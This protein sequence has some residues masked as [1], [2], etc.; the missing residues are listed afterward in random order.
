MKVSWYLWQPPVARQEEEEQEE[1]E[2]GE[3]ED[4]EEEV[5]E[6]EVEEKKKE[7]EEITVTM[8]TSFTTLRLFLS[9]SLL[10]PWTPVW[11]SSY[12]VLLCVK[13]I[14]YCFFLHLFSW[15]TFKKAFL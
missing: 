7:E 8:V 15:E 14:R 1:E 13:H 2:E 6:E 4:K 10:T 12:L 11:V 5:E 9:A 3:K